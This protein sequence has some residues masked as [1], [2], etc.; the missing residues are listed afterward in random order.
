MKCDECGETFEVT[1]C[2]GC[3]GHFC[4]NCFDEHICTDDFYD[5]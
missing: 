3:T 4:T 5:D 2:S 1:S